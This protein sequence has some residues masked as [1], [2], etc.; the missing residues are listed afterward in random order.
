MSVPLIGYGF[1]HWD[2]AFRARE[3][4]GALL[5]CLAWAFL[6]AGTLWLNAVLDDDD[7]DVLWGGSGTA[8]KG[9][10]AIAFAALGLSVVCAA[11]A[12]P[13]AGLCTALCAILAVLYSHPLT[14][15]KGHPVMGL[16]VNVLGYGALSLIAGWSL[17]Q[18][19]LTPRA[20][21]SLLA[22]MVW[23][24]AAALLAQAFQ[25]DADRARGYRTP[26]VIWGAEKTANVARLLFGIGTLS[27]LIFTAIGWYPRVVL[28]CAPLWL[29]VDAQLATRPLTSAWAAIGFR[30]V[31]VFGL[32]VLSTVL[33]AHLVSLSSGGP[34]A[35]L[36][37]ARGWP[38]D[39]VWVRERRMQ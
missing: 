20:V 34:T 29:W 9:T 15:W 26:V 3:L 14:V 4:S 36:D 5:L 12:G 35:G 27:L 13:V 21:A 6:H 23:V 31:C 11:V 16:V 1:A 30:R 38:A 2:G 24:A 39:R 37:T 28:L 18:V 25:E 7:G 32:V 17:P 8:P 19:S 22:F 10:T 33:A